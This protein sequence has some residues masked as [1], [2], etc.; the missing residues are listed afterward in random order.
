MRAKWSRVVV[1]WCI[2]LSTVGA[3]VH[4]QCD[5]QQIENTS[6]KGRVACP[7]FSPGE[8]G[9]ALFELSPEAY[10]VEILRVAV[11]WG[12]QFVDAPDSIERALQ[13][14]AGS[15]ATLGDP[16]YSVPAPVLRDGAVN[17]LTIDP[18]QRPV[19]DGPFVVA[20]EFE[21]MSTL[22][23]ATMVHDG[24]GCTPGVNLVY[25]TDGTWVDACGL[26]LT[27]NWVVNATYRSINCGKTS[28]DVPFRRTLLN[29]DDTGDLSD[30]VFLLNFLFAGGEAP[31]CENAADMN[32]DTELDLTDAIF[33]LN[34][35]FAGG[36]SPAPPF[37][38]C[39]VDATENGLGCAAFAGC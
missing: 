34:F 12:S 36:E 17:E 33:F 19:V 21:N 32:D 20:L 30:A 3:T 35:L 7:C 11:G 8:R 18:A 13:I 16:I 2:A 14:Y 38:E 22:F 31:T 10:P 39:G 29:S 27:G 26:G 1:P 4:G 28:T 5:E 23:G 15:P 9:G 24:A 6:G 25:T 37:E